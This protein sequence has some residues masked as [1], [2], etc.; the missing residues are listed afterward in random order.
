MDAYS[1]ALILEPEDP[2]YDENLIR[3]SVTGLVKKKAPAIISML[4]I[5]LGGEQDD[6]VHMGIKGLFL[7][8]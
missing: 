8:R 3:D 5:I 1:S 4:R 2:V 6:F 7:S